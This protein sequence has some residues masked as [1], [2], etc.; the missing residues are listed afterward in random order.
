MWQ[1]LAKVLVVSIIAVFAVVG[2]AWRGAAPAAAADAC[3]TVSTTP[4]SLTFVNN[5]GAPVNIYWSDFNCVEVPT[6]TTLA[7]GAS[8]TQASFVSHPWIVR[9]AG[10]GNALLCFVATGDQTV[11]I[12]AGGFVN[13]CAGTD[14]RL[15]LNLCDDQVAVYQNFDEDGNPILDVWGIET[16]TDA[17]DQLQV[18]GRYLF[19]I[20]ESDL[21]DFEENLPEEN[22]RLASENG[23]RAYI[24]TSGEVQINTPSNAEGKQCVLIFDSLQPARMGHYT[25]GN[26]PTNT[27]GTPA[28]STV[29]TN[30]PAPTATP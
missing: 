9:D 5:S 10:T 30:T 26:Q 23:I 1:R 12:N 11:T 13:N 15:N 3:S 16:V 2:F 4:V 18:V 14:G 29:S 27:G 28:G 22:T 24:L 19:S 20:G 17:N 25:F 7:N 21:A 8:T 6:V